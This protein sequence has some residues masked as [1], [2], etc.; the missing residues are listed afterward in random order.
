VVQGARLTF[1]VLAAAAAVTVAACSGGSS[2]AVAPVPSATS[3]PQFPGA[4]PGQPTAPPATP[5]PGQT[6]TPTPVPTAT[7]T[8]TPTPGAPGTTGPTSTPAPAIVKLGAYHVSPQQ[9]FVAGISSGGFFG[10]QMH[11]AHSA[12]FRGAAIYAGGVFH[13]AQDSVELALIECGG[14]TV[15]GQALYQSTLAQSNAYLDQQ[16]AA[17]TIDASSNLQNQPVYLWSGTRDSVVNPKEMADL[18]AQYLHYGARVTFDSAIPAEHGWE[19]PDGEL[20]CG[21]VASPYMIAC[22]VNGQPYDSEQK[23]LSAFFGPLTPRASGALRGSLMRFDQT[24][25][26]ASAANSMDT[27]GTVFVP[28]TCAAGATCGF[29]VVFHG[30]HQGH[31]E[32]GDKFVTQS[33]IDEWA[34]TNKIIVLYPYAVPAPGPFPYNP[35]GCWDWWGYDDANYSLKSGTQ[36][37]IV[38]RMVQRVTGSP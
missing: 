33:G 16:S 8:A 11:V 12:V 20:P 34:D 25:F 5:P 32:I 31:G 36:T 3:S 4:G 22:S 19:S 2:S 35:N 28:Q 1:S 38:Y 29:V 26:G 9:I 30:C 10:V 7:P 23:W 14:E 17:A 13:C 18:N 6:P 24:E 15:N 21:T 37:S 27:N